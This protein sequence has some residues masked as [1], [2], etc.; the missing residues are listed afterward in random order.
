MTKSKIFENGSLF[1]PDVAGIQ[2]HLDT[3]DRILL[4]A[5]LEIHEKGFQAASLAQILK[6]TGV[7][8]GA[9][10]HHFPSKKELGYAVVDELLEEHMR[11]FWV[12]PLERG[13]N[14]IDTLIEILNLARERVSERDIQ[15]GCPVNNLAQEM[16]PID[17]GF[18]IRIDRTLSAWRGGIAD[19][20]KEGQEAGLVKTDFDANSMATL[21]VS[22]LQGTIGMAKN[23]QNRD[24]LTQCGMSLGYFLNSLRKK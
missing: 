11:L 22:S 17:E 23:A 15:L 2:E 1:E 12:D 4:A 6:H 7:T 13:M 20:L 8:K 9:L 16:S 5:F 18:R 19:A 14:P 21:L 10:Y 3:R 24:V